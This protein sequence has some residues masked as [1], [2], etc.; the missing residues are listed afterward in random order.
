MT[1]IVTTMSGDSGKSLSRTTTQ[2][3]GWARISV[4]YG[5]Q[6]ASVD[7][8]V[9]QSGQ[10]WLNT[11]GRDGVSSVKLVAELDL[12]TGSFNEEVTDP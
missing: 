6:Q 11:R 3:P 1:K 5:V 10:V 9:T 8:T 7:V 12:E 4:P 2:G